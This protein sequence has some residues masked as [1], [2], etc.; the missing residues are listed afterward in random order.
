[1]PPEPRLGS[2]QPHW[3]PV[4][5]EST[6]IHHLHTGR[7]ASSSQKSQGPQITPVLPPQWITRELWLFR[8]LD[9]STLHSFIF[10]IG[11]GDGVVPSSGITGRVRRDRSHHGNDNQRNDCELNREKGFGRCTFHCRYGSVISGLC[12]K[13]PKDRFPSSDSETTNKN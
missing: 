8:N 4:R 11:V 13:K 5:A 6:Q 3:G 7:S 10:F 9:F 1:M 2:H 12:W